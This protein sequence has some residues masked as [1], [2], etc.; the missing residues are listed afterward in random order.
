MF[1]D[2]TGYDE[3][4]FR[5]LL[6]EFVRRNFTPPEVAHYSEVRVSICTPSPSYDM[7]G[8][9]WEAQTILV[10]HKHP[11]PR[12]AGPG[13]DRGVR[14]WRERL[15]GKTPDAPPSAPQPEP[16]ADEAATADE[17]PAEEP[18]EAEDGSNDDATGR[19]GTWVWACSTE[20]ANWAVGYLVTEAGNIDRP[21]VFLEASGGDSSPDFGSE[22]AISAVWRLA[23]NYADIGRVNCIE[24]RDKGL[25]NSI[26]PMP[27][28]VYAL[29]CNRI[30]RAGEEIEGVPEQQ[31]HPFCKFKLDLMQKLAPKS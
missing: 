15:E 18:T 30:N 16:A 6:G 7:D 17:A 13:P 10:I 31:P 12:P 14:G 2:G 22:G 9:S 11:L 24:L 19:E 1:D 8:D 3:R 29:R 28:F 25:P 26:M 23:D 20:M 21:I 5:L 4:L 27:E